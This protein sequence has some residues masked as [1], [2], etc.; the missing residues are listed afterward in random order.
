MQVYAKDKYQF[1]Q[2]GEV[3]LENFPLKF[4]NWMV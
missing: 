2:L 4:Y 1:L 3:R